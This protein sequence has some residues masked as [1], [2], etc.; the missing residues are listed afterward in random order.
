MLGKNKIRDPD[1]KKRSKAHQ[2]GPVL[3]G[4]KKEELFDIAK[5]I[6][7]LR[8]ERAEYKQNVKQ[9]KAAY[10]DKVRANEDLMYQKRGLLRG[11][12]HTLDWEIQDEAE[13]QAAS[14]RAEYE[15]AKDDLKLLETAI[16]AR[17]KEYDAAKAELLQL[18]G[19]EIKHLKD[20]RNTILTKLKDGEGKTVKD[21]LEWLV[22]A[23]DRQYRTLERILEEGA[24]RYPLTPTS[25]PGGASVRAL[26]DRIGSAAN[27][28]EVA[29][30][31]V[32]LSPQKGR[33]R[34]RVLEDLMLL[35]KKM[36][37]Q[38]WSIRELDARRHAYIGFR[39]AIQNTKSFWTFVDRMGR[40]HTTFLK[41]GKSVTGVT[42]PWKRV[43]EGTATKQKSLT[44]A[45]DFA[46]ELGVGV[47][48]GA[49]DAIKLAEMGLSILVSGSISHD[50]DRRLRANLSVK[51]KPNLKVEISGCGASLFE[52]T[53]SLGITIAN[54]TYAFVD[55]EHFAYYLSFRVANLVH[56]TSKFSEYSHGRRAMLHQ[57]LDVY[58]PWC[59]ELLAEMMKPGKIEEMKTYLSRTPIVKAHRKFRGAPD[60]DLGFKS[61]FVGEAG[62]SGSWQRTKFQ[63]QRLLLDETASASPPAP[64]N[65]E[66]FDFWRYRV[67]TRDDSLYV[68]LSFLLAQEGIDVE[69]DTLK[70]EAER[71]CYQRQQAK[72]T[73]TQNEK[74]IERFRR[75]NRRDRSQVQKLESEIEVL[76]E[77][78]R[79][80]S[81]RRRIASKENQIQENKK[82][83][84]I[85]QARIERLEEENRDLT[86]TDPSEQEYDTPRG[87]ACDLAVLAYRYNLRIRIHTTARKEYASPTTDT[88]LSPVEFSEAQVEGFKAD[89]RHLNPS[90]RTVGPD[91]S[92]ILKSGHPVRTLHV[93]QFGAD[94]GSAFAEAPGYKKGGRG[95]DGSGYHPLIPKRPENRTNPPRR[96]GAFRSF[97]GAPGKVSKIRYDTSLQ[98]TREEQQAQRAAGHRLLTEVRYGTTR[99]LSGSLNVTSWVKVGLGVGYTYIAANANVDNDGHYLNVKVDGGLFA[100][101]LELDFETAYK[102]SY[103]ADLE[104]KASLTG[105]EQKKLA[106]LKSDLE[107]DYDGTSAEGAYDN[108][109]EWGQGAMPAI[110]DEASK[111]AKKL[112]GSLPEKMADLAVE[113]GANGL[114]QITLQINRTRRFLTFNMIRTEGSWRLQYIRWEYNQASKIGASGSIPTGF[115]VDPSLTGSVSWSKTVALQ[116]R[117]GANTLTYALT[118]FNGLKRRP[119]GYNQWRTFLEKNSDRLRVLFL[120]VAKQNDGAGGAR[121]E[122]QALEEQANDNRDV[123]K[124]SP[125]AEHESDWRIEGEPHPIDF[126]GACERHQGSLTRNRSKKKKLLTLKRDI[127]GGARR[128]ALPNALVQGLTTLFW[129]ASQVAEAEHNAQFPWRQ[130]TVYLTPPKGRIRFSIAFDE[131]HRTF[132]ASKPPVVEGRPDS[133]KEILEASTSNQAYFRTTI[134]DVL[135]NPDLFEAPS[136]RPFYEQ[137]FEIHLDIHLP[138]N[139]RVTVQA[140]QPG[141]ENALRDAVLKMARE[142]REAAKKAREPKVYKQRKATK[143]ADMQEAFRTLLK[144]HPYLNTNVEEWKIASRKKDLDTDTWEEHAQRT[145]SRF[146]KDA[147]PD[148]FEQVL[149]KIKGPFWGLPV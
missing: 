147:P 59:K 100:R 14:E 68:S 93:V 96:G 17:K 105:E 94:E 27:V 127:W 149:E 11:M 12:S 44:G 65:D 95:P 43:T 115:G 145:W 143:A 31:D 130:K 144:V 50:D 71:A 120:N 84:A 56:F 114:Q 116:E 48:V 88:S 83:V 38:I 98:T 124:N 13:A 66:D 131:E 9:R 69:P 134:V 29:I 81:H 67:K 78:R 57:H 111:L 87:K 141:G 136:I 129:R 80:S 117:L 32:D 6:S 74:M 35:E 47:N 128:E 4:E 97:L 92:K 7:R 77:A 113:A 26:K 53:A 52:L 20:Q 1:L 82:R 33:V 46:I 109:E 58:S 91:P 28:K 37:R 137:S 36:A 142:A 25:K 41:L 123:W 23:R 34:E 18:I 119:D 118:V 86:P 112:F 85:R 63:R 22:A 16:K 62:A 148:W 146:V 108:F 126:V 19:R 15:R 121:A 76:R 135:R 70:L 102:E 40:W 132:V 61:T 21:H 5:K 122:A 140:R 2:I 51:L 64:A 60:L 133:T 107:G 125:W 99:S 79:P 73:R 110:K 24:V 104:D 103:K 3:L 8:R 42:R 49:G 138:H 39:E 30:E 89:A 54:Q 90:T 72:T 101:T 45:R 106:E 75:E 55:A 139:Q 10:W